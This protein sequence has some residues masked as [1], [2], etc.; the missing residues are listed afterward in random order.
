MAP[1]PLQARQLALLLYRRSSSRPA[2]ALLARP[3]ILRLVIL[4]GVPSGARSARRR[5]PRLS[6][7][8]S[9]LPAPSLCFVLPRAAPWCSDPASR[10]SCSHGSASSRFGQVRPMAPGLL[11]APA[12]CCR[13]LQPGFLFVTQLGACCSSLLRVS[14]SSIAR[15][16]ILCSQRRVKFPRRTPLVRAGRRLQADSWLS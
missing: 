15:T 4:L 10:A 6:P 8:R 7:A 12:P 9:D 3:A 13:E 14:H 1:D 5:K 2:R 16:K 11:L